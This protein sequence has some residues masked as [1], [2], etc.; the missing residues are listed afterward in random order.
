M[1]KKRKYADGGDVAP[2]VSVESRKRPSE[3]GEPTFM[4]AVGARL[5]M[6][7]GYGNPKSP[8]KG[9]GLPTIKGAADKISERKKQLDSYADGGKVTS[10]RRKK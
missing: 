10:K 9:G 4:R 6:G 3:F 7:D 2:L 1:A 5:G 8:P